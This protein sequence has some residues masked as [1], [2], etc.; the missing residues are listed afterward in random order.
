[1]RS[2]LQ[3]LNQRL[4]PSEM[5][6]VTGLTLTRRVLESVS[7]ESRGTVSANLNIPAQRN[8]L[9]ELKLRGSDVPRLL[10]GVVSLRGRLECG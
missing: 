10:G 6:E 4:F 2:W 3:F 9:C 8:E 1:M 5:R 7:K